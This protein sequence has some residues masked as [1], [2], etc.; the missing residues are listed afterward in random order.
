[1]SPDSFLPGLFFW[2]MNKNFCFLKTGCISG[3]IKH[4][5]NHRI[6][7]VFFDEN[8]SPNGVTFLFFFY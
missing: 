1:M 6:F 8:F 3:F 2:I 7:L 4:M 5:D